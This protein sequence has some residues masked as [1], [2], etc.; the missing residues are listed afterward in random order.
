MSVARDMMRAYRAP[1]EVFARRLGDTAREDRALAVLMVACILI[2]VAQ[3]PR[4]QRVALETGQDLNPLL[5]GALFGWLFIVPLTAYAIA[6]ISH[7]IAR[8]MG[9]QGS[10]FGARFALFWALL[11]ASPLWLFWGL[12]SGFV[13]AGAAETAVGAVALG[14]FLVHWVVNLLTAERGAGAAA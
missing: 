14:A 10:W 9:G 5:G 7:M 3:A 11:V 1:R 6:A 2:F 4:L 13:G 8:L 12:V